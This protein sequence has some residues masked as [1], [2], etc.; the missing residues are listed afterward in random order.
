MFGN[1][2]WM[3]I[4]A[5]GRW[6]H[7]MEWCGRIQASVR[8]CHFFSLNYSQERLLIQLQCDWR[9]YS[10]TVNHMFPKYLIIFG[11]HNESQ[12]KHSPTHIHATFLSNGAHSERSGERWSREILLF[13]SVALWGSKVEPAA[14]SSSRPAVI[15]RATPS[16]PWLSAKSSPEPP[17]PSSYHNLVIYSSAQL[18]KAVRRR[19]PHHR[20][21]DAKAL[22]CHAFQPAACQGDKPPRS[23]NAFTLNWNEDLRSFGWHSKMQLCRLTRGTAFD[24][25]PEWLIMYYRDAFVRGIEVSWQG[26]VCMQGQIF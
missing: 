1:K 2:N 15:L 12:C 17:P 19:R 25:L 5:A 9:Y 11:C 16:W 18:S 21:R 23:N 22:P 4:I 13:H 8:V 20:S 6:R 14:F 24:N 3:G 7:D 26:Q 10:S